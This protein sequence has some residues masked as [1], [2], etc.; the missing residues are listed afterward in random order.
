[1]ARSCAVLTAHT[2]TTYAPAR[3]HNLAPPTPNLTSRA[4]R[5]SVERANLAEHAACRNRNYAARTGC[6]FTAFHDADVNASLH[7]SWHKAPLILDAITRHPNRA[8]LWLDSDAV[9]QDR[10][11]SPTDWL[12]ICEQHAPPGNPP[13]QLVLQSTPQ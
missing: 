11:A 7:P 13:I 5:T 4:V 8:V 3:G 12:R 6:A 2:F 9:V 1:M 10:S